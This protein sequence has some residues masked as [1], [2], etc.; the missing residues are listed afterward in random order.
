MRKIA[1]FFCF[2]FF[3]FC[4]GQEKTHYLKAAV[5]NSFTKLPLANVY[6][7]NLTK[8]EGVISDGSGFFEMEVSLKDTLYFTYLGYKSIKIV[9]SNDMIKYNNTRVQMA[10]IAFALEEVIIYPYRLTGYLDID[11]K[12]LPYNPNRRYAIRGVSNAGYETGN[13]DR[14][15]VTSFFDA[16]HD[17][18]DFLN[19]LFSS[20]VGSLKKLKKARQNRN[21]R[22]L[23]VNKFDRALIKQLLG[24]DLIDIEAILVHCNYSSAFIKNANDLQVLEAI[25]DCYEEYKILNNKI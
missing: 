25:N 16:I 19:N 22:S 21:I 9:V 12:Y 23:L 11:I 8:I 1:I 13:R 5:E 4:V 2:L 10:E 17:P 15:S 18:F 3:V 20:K 7:V 6:I 24:M 14:F